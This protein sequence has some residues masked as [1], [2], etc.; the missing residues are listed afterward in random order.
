MVFHF[1]H[2][3]FPFLLLL[4][5]YYVLFVLFCFGF[6]FFFLFF[7]SLLFLSFYMFHM[8]S[9]VICTHIL[10][11]VITLSLQRVANVGF[12]RLYPFHCFSFEVE[13]VPRSLYKGLKTFLFSP[14]FYCFREEENKSLRGS[15][16]LPAEAL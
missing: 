13:Q 14:C 6:S 16:P 1:L 5:F 8:Y 2:T 12:E 7:V 10:D 11:G 4:F 15:F 3:L 9:F